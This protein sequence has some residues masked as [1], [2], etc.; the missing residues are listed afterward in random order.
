MPPSVGIG[1]PQETSQRVGF[2][3]SRGGG[4]CAPAS[5]DGCAGFGFAV[6][7][8]GWGRM[9]AANLA[10][11]GVRRVPNGPGLWPGSFGARF[12][13]AR[14]WFAAIIGQNR[15]QTLKSDRFWVPGWP[16]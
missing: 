14:A 2:P 3:R 6:G 10:R 8:P 15:A 16:R 7:G 12:S 13:A 5:L 4:A 9:L 11:E 1:A